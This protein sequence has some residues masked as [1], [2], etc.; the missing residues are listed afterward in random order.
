LDVVN[1]AWSLAL[2]VVPAI[3]FPVAA[4]NFYRAH[5]GGGIALNLWILQRTRD[6]ERKWQGK[7]VRDPRVDS[8]RRQEVDWHVRHA[9]EGSIKLDK[10]VSSGLLPAVL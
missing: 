6:A 7:R 10:Q 4:V 1:R 5:G 2:L 3:G 8:V 9:E